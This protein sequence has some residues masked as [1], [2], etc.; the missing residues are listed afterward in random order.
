LFTHRRNRTRTERGQSIVEFALV[1]PLMLFIA[2][3]VVDLARI[4]TTMLSVES[5]ARE[6]ADFGTF[7]SEKWTPGAVDATVANMEKSACVASSDLP[8]YQ[9]PDDN[10]ANPVF[11]YCMSPDGGAT[12]VPYSEGLTCDNPTREPPCRV[13]VTLAYTFNLIVPLS[14]EAFGVRYGFPNSITFERTNTFAMTDLE[15]DP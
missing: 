10:C 15:L 1:L 2:L 12:C 14:I 8:D 11:T 7:G 9:G 4:Y 13:S 3:A 6:A 5:A